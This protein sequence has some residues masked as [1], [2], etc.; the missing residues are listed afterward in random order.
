MNL[1]AVGGGIWT[2]TNGG[3]AWND[4]T[5]SQEQWANVASDATGKN[6]VAVVRGFTDRPGLGSGGFDGDIWTSTNGGEAW[7]NRTASSAV[8]HQAWSAVASDSSGT[9]LVAVTIGGS[10]LLPTGAIWTSSD[11]GATWTNQTANKGTQDWV[12][13]ASD[14]TGQKLV[15][16]GA[17]GIWTSSDSGLTWTDRK[18]DG[19]EN[20]WVSVASDATGTNLIAVADDGGNMWRSTD[21]GVTWTQVSSA[22]TGVL[23]SVASD[24]TGTN[25]VAADILVE[26]TNGDV[27][28]SKDSGA[29]W[30]NMTAPSGASGPWRGVATNASGSHSVAIGGGSI[31]TD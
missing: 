31:W 10:A 8:H 23:M 18:V 27:W 3:T 30:S 11:S 22:P 17:T 19:N 15:V 26:G 21:S 28:T 5:P 4:K 12:S 16:A 7:T 20:G 2:S 29:T 9:H 1:V 24:A 13:V 14:S 6:L 25:L